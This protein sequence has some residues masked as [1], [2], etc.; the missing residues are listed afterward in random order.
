MWTR[1]QLKE[2]AKK[3]LSKNYWKA[4]LVTLVLITVTGAGSGA[5]SGASNGV[6]G[7][8][9][10]LYK[11][12]KE[13]DTKIVLND[14]GDDKEKDK[15]QDKDKN[16]DNGKSADVNVDLGKD[17]KFSIK[18][19]NGKVYINGKEIN[20]ENGEVKVNINGKSFYVNSKDGKVKYDGNEF[21]IGDASGSVSFDNG[22]LVIKD[23]E[24]NSVFNGD[25]NRGQEAIGVA[26]GIFAVVFGVLMFFICVIGTLLE[27]FVMNPIKV[28]GYNFF[29][30]QREGTSRFT[31]IFGG[32]THG[33]YKASIRNMFL[34]DLY[35]FLWSM[36]FII[37][38]IIKSYSYWMVPYIT[39]ANP[40]L[41][42]SRVFEI[43]K[44]TM[45]GEKWRTFVL[46]LSF[47]GWELLAI[48]TFGIGA[49]FLA[50]YQ[51]TTYA[52]LYAV[53]RQKAIAN[54]I[55]TEEELAIAA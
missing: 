9:N 48:L 14:D 33:H 55:A 52:E 35:E 43:S 37:P 25:I 7:F 20:D 38:G 49:Y 11:S 10:S 41:S 40:N 51:E 1:K 34:K 13:A 23:G 54:G 46:Q 18:V 24:G 27:I 5:F 47:I 22:K 12:K 45:S 17:G 4:F 15:D 3:I 32:F 26:L 28:G 6:S 29:N 44:K 19:D 31:N 21:V 36:L 53:L 8:S 30:R 39:A 16:S 50:P 2:N 42:A